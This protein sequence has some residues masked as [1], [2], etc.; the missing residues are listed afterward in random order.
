MP[1]C[2]ERFTNTSCRHVQKHNVTCTR[3]HRLCR[4]VVC[5]GNEVAPSDGSSQTTCQQSDPLQDEAVEGRSGVTA[6]NG[7]LD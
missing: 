2:N 5:S 7:V 6:D 1:V 3:K 4:D